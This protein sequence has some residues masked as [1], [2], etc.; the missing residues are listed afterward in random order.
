MHEK[1]VVDGSSGRGLRGSEKTFCQFVE[2]SWVASLFRGSTFWRAVG[3]S[4]KPLRRLW[5]D[6]LGP[7]GGLRGLILALLTAL[8]APGPLLGLSRAAPWALLGGLGAPLGR[9]WRLLAAPGPLLGRPGALLAAPGRPL[10]PFWR[11]LSGSWSSLGGSKVALCRK[12][13]I[14]RQYSVFRGFLGLR[15]LTWRLLRPSW[16]SLGGPWGPPGGSWVVLGTA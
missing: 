12:A 15:E 7:L 9:S 10:G 1:S 16:V 6:L 13:R 4:W 11:L 14:R 2:S 8:G 5:G 3:A